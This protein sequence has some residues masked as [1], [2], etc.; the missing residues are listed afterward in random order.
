[1]LR[2]PGAQPTPRGDVF[3]CGILLYEMLTGQLPLAPLTPQDR[4][5]DAKLADRIAYYRS[6]RAVPIPAETFRGFSAELVEVVRQA[7]LVDA[8]RRFGDAGLMLAALRAVAR[9]T[10]GAMPDLADEAS[11][12]TD[13]DARD[14]GF[15]DLSKTVVS[16]PLFGY[17]EEPRR[18]AGPGAPAGQPPPARAPFGPD[19]PTVIL[20]PADDESTLETSVDG[21]E[22]GKT[23]ILS[24]DRPGRADLFADPF[25]AQAGAGGGEQGIAVARTMVQEPSQPAEARTMILEP[26]GQGEAQPAGPP[27]PQGRQ[28]PVA[29][30]PQPWPVGPGAAPAWMHAPPRPGP[31][32]QPALPGAAGATDARR[33]RRR[34]V[35]AVIALVVFA[36]GLFV[37]AAAAWTLA[38]R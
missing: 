33:G 35:A 19:I 22:M 27:A 30:A 20:E 16:E 17:E 6:G 2:Q 34:L 5:I 14:Q 21:D 9:A 7:T 8:A 23:T 15:V 13:V 3:A 1:V 12:D 18:A 4:T 37:V 29:V 28:E 36:I 10:P 32:A 24:A 25:A 31:Q 26:G 38:L 11:I